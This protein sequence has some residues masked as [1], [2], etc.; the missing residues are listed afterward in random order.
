MANLDT[1]SRKWK[2]SPINV[3][4]LNPGNGTPIALSIHIARSV[5]QLEHQLGMQ[6]YVKHTFL[7]PT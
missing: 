3:T 7:K 6:N 4:D 1:Y 5:S 2:L